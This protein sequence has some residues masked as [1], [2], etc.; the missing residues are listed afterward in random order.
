VTHHG[1]PT[2]LTNGLTHYI[3]KILP[4]ATYNGYLMTFYAYLDSQYGDF[5]LTT[6][7]APG[8]LTFD[9]NLA[10]GEVALYTRPVYIDYFY[11]EFDAEEYAA[12]DEAFVNVNITASIKADLTGLPDAEVSLFID[13][14]GKDDSKGTVKFINGTRVVELNFN[15]EEAFNNGTMN[16]LII[17]NADAEMKVVVTCA[18]DKNDA[19]QHDNDNITACADG[20]NMQGDIFVDDTKVADL[21]DRNGLPVF[22]FSD[23]S[24]YDLVI[25]PNFIVQPSAP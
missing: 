21:E 16:H 20:I 24:G 17:R 10:A 15:S 7:H 1:A 5:T 25:T 23:G 14:L 19:G 18:T 3:A 6:G 9:G 4:E 13:R 2:Q 12:G 8:E 22:T 11:P